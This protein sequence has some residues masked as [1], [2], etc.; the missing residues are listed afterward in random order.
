MLRTIVFDMGNVLLHFSHERMCRQIAA[1]CGQDTADVRRWLFEEGWEHAFERGE[2]TAD[3]FH[4]RLAQRSG[5]DIDRDQ[6]RLAAADIF[7]LNEPLVPVLAR[8]RA[9]EL[10]LVLLSNTH[11]WHLDFVRERF[12]ILQPFDALVVSYEVGALKPEPAI[13]AAAADAL[14]CLP[15]EAY[16]TDDIPAY[17][18]MGRR[19][20][21]HADVFHD[22]PRLC[23]Q[24]T[25]LGITGLSTLTD[26]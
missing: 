13:Y 9:A 11:L 8:L 10:R 12:Q 5:R 3:E 18:E 16:Y 26:S 1:L 4:A 20:G 14:H 21:W 24:L 25:A 19:M 6:L 15:H 22:V 23:Q 7:T 2:I 17:V